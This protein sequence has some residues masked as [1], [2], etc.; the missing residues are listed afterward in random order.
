[1]RGKNGAAGTPLYIFVAGEITARC[2]GRTR[3][4]ALRLAFKSKKWFWSLWLWFDGW[5]VG[6]VER[7]DDSSMVYFAG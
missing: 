7:S 6:S 2:C 3:V 1:M 4:A 5:H